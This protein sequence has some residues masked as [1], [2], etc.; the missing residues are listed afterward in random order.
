MKRLVVVGSFYIS[1]LLL[2]Y[3][4]IGWLSINIVDKG[5]FVIKLVVFYFFL[6]FDS[7]VLLKDVKVVII[8]EDIIF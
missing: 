8:G 3:F 6:V 7:D 5:S 1:R 4:R 2:N